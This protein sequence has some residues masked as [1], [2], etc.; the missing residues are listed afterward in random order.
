MLNQNLLEHKMLRFSIGQ[1]VIISGHCQIGEFVLHEIVSCVSNEENTIYK[2]RSVK[3]K[4]ILE[5]K[6]SQLLSIQEVFGA[7]S[8]FRAGQKVVVPLYFEN[9]DSPSTV[10]EYE[11]ISINYNIKGPSYTIKNIENNLIYKIYENKLT[12]KEKMT[13]RDLEK[14]SAQHDES[15]KSDPLINGVRISHIISAISL[16]EESGFDM[17]NI[18]LASQLHKFNL[19]K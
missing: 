19:D 11:I 17:S 1:K 4:E 8:R 14:M 18:D 7:E 3:T 9:S 16:L 2:I 6:E 12:G 10:T 15:L 5:L 13:D